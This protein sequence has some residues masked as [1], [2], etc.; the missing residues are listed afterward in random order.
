[1]TLSLFYVPVSLK[2]HPGNVPQITNRLL[3]L[4]VASRRYFYML[5]VFCLICITE[6]LWKL[7]T[8]WTVRRKFALS[9]YMCISSDIILLGLARWVM[10]GSVP[11]NQ[12]VRM[13]LCHRQWKVKFLLVQSGSCVSSLQC[14][15]ICLLVLLVHLVLKL[16][17][18]TVV[19]SCWCRAP[20]LPWRSTMRTSP[21]FRTSS[22]SIFV[23]QHVY[24]LFIYQS[25]MWGQVLLR[26]FW[27]SP[28][29]IWVKVRMFGP[30]DQEVSRYLICYRIYDSSF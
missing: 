25:C 22:V 5:Y 9:H 17:P 2:K 10:M 29:T 8:N 7:S 4:R 12:T 30:W 19:L 23:C 14:F 6:L 16:L 28:D 15:A 1:M 27:L 20:T 3:H 26:E 18:V 21:S 24:L 11:W 13:F